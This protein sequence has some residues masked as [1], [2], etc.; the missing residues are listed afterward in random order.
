MSLTKEQW[1]E[2]ET[3]LSLV[4]LWR[5][6]VKLMCDGYELTAQVVPISH[7][8]AVIDIRIDGKH[9]QARYGENI[10]EIAHKFMC[11]RKRFTWPLGVRKEAQT[12]ARKRRASKEIKEYSQLVMTRQHSIFWPTWNSP[13]S[14]CRHLRKT[15]QSIELIGVDY[16]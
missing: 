9:L 7:L 2:V 14:L 3:A 11:E 5:R 15:C 1:K 12:M 13:V 6:A 16:E 10:D 8:Q 4:G